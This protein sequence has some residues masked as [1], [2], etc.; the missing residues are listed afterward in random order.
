LLRP[1]RRRVA[2][3][4]YP[5]GASLGVGGGD[6]ERLGI[7]LVAVALVIGCRDPAP[8]DPCTCTPAN[9]GQVRG[10]R[11]APPLDGPALVGRLRVH[12]Q[13]VRDRRNPRDVKVF[14]DELR[15]AIGD[16]CHPCN[17]WVRERS[18]IEELYPIER[19]DDARSAVCLGLV[20]RDNATVYGDDRPRA[21][22]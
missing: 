9:A 2:C 17:D 4:Q 19:L 14:D 22:R 8:P 13:M 20:V 12:R 5:V 10:P 1:A 21:C 11:D 6:G 15:L 18:T 3:P 16:F 7:V